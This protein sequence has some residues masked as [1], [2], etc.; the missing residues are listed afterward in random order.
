MYTRL[1]GVPLVENT[2]KITCRHV[3]FDKKILNIKDNQAYP[4]FTLPK[5][6]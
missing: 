2:N 1:P 6:S 5:N 3:E 4:G